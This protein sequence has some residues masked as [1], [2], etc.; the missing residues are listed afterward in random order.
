MPWQGFQNIDLSSVVND[1]PE[2]KRILQRGRHV[3]K[4]T[5][6]TI[7]SDESKGTHQLELSYENSDG[8]IRQWI[9]VNHK[10]EKAVEIGLQ[11]VKDLLL[12]LGHD[13]NSTP[14]VA[15]FKGK[16]VGINV[17]D[18]TYNG[19]TRPRVNYT[20]K[21]EEGASTDAKGGIPNDEI[22]F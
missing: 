20:F 15:W 11:Q 8:V 12:N 10:S 19:T 6:A 17:K 1:R 21:A 2:S 13:G 9:I 16:T 22:P 5:D 18:D 3:V 4:I 14:A 7:A